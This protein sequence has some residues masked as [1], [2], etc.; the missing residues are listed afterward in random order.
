MTRG[1]CGPRSALRYPVAPND[2]GNDGGF[3]TTWLRPPSPWIGHRDRGSPEG[4]VPGSHVQVRL[5]I[6]ARHPLGS[7]IQKPR[8]YAGISP[9]CRAGRRWS[10]GA[11][12]DPGRRMT[13]HASTPSWYVLRQCGH[14]SRFVT[15]SQ[16]C[17]RRP[18]PPNWR[19]APH[20]GHSMSAL[21][22]RAKNRPTR[23][24]SDSTGSS[25]LGVM[26]PTV[27]RFRES[28]SMGS[29]RLGV[30]CAQD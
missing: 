29:P 4:S 8:S 23:S 22:M 27:E 12:V 16:Y 15:R 3:G 17:A 20:V 1:C 5:V 30:T 7:V 19:T 25:R 18:R 14:L 10:S 2:Y 24:E 6:S 13:G 21:R 28:D 26:S 11:L 9:R